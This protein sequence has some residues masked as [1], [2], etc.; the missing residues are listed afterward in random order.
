MK[1]A[2]SLALVLVFSISAF[3]QSDRPKELTPLI[4]SK[5]KA[6]VDKDAITFKQTLSKKD[7]SAS[8]ITFSVDTFK[9]EQIAAKRMEVDYSTAGMNNTMNDRAASYDKLLNKYYKILLA[10]LKP[11]DKATLIATQRSWINYRDAES[12]LIYTMGKQEYSGGGTIQS[13]IASTA[14]ADLVVERT[15]KIFNYYNS[16]VN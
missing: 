10:A 16:I 7:L 1:H 9:V 8:E 14:Y 4:L 3:A 2:V 11:A 6:D 13:N 12:K 5:I 15:L